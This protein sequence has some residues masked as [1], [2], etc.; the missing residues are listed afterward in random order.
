MEKSF[1]PRC[2]AKFGINLHNPK[3]DIDAIWDE[4]DKDGK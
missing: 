1:L 3:A 2:L 4:M